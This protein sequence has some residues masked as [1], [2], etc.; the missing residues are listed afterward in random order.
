MIDQSLAFLDSGIGGLPYL[1][2]I[3][4]RRP[5]LP[6][7]Y[8]ADTAHFPYGELSNADIIQAVVQAAV[9]IFSCGTPRI[10]TVACNTA[11]VA[12]L[13]EIREFAPCPV[14][15]TVPAVKSAASIDNVGAIGVLATAGTV[16]SAYLNRLVSAF[17]P[18]R[19]IV[20]VA[21]GDIV[22][23]VEERWLDE[24]DMGAIPV[25][26][27]ALGL[28]KAEKVGTVVI[29]CTHFLHVIE[30]IQRLLGPEV[31]LVDSRDGVGRRILALL[32][33]SETKDTADGDSSFGD[34]WVT[35]DGITNKRYRR[36]SEAHRLDWAG[37]LP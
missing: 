27:R 21:A 22:R 14:V 31:K 16:E 32:G 37:L 7:S 18:G 23:Y 26:E 19:R 13:D 12:A 10:L 11:S 2:W 28:M 33:E 25:M 30:P 15:G 4:S 17:A 20:K 1:D 24:G 35:L 3:T 8:I 6:V 29:G 34:F 36:F 5:D 9:K